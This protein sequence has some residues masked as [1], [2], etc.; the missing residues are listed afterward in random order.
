[1]E[2]A[3]RP[4]PRAGWGRAQLS[5][6]PS[7]CSQKHL[8]AGP[9]LVTTDNRSLLSPGQRWGSGWSGRHMVF[10][11]ADPGVNPSSAVYWPR[12]RWVMT[13]SARVHV[14]RLPCGDGSPYLADFCEDWRWMCKAS[15]PQQPL[16]TR[17]VPLF[18]QQSHE[19]YSSAY[20]RVW[21]H[22]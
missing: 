16:H 14:P 22:S 13:R 12:N 9:P 6:P 3:L 17:A 8:F 4:E 5:S 10:A 19:L 1:M 18:P 11:V 7:S 2:V 21:F 15:G 20:C